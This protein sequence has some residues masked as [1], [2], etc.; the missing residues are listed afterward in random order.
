MRA[1]CR[2]HNNGN[3]APKVYEPWMGRELSATSMR[4]NLG[5]STQDFQA[6]KNEIRFSSFKLADVLNLIVLIMSGVSWVTGLEATET[7]RL[8]E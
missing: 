8:C 5:V 3:L 7:H 1:K 4:F 6:P 2:W